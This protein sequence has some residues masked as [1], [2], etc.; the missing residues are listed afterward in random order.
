[1]KVRA[2]LNPRAGVA[3]SRAREAVESGRSSWRDYAVYLTRGAGHATE[4]AREA[5]TAG[6]DLVL[7]VGGD[8]TANEVAQGLLGSPAALGIVPVGSGNGLARALRIPLPPREALAALESGARRR[9]DVGFLNGRPFL[10]VAGVGFDAAVG[11]A[12]HEH[13]RRGG[14]RGLLGYVWL[15]LLALRSYHPPRLTIDVAPERL[16]L[17]AFVATFANGPQYGSGA[18][19]NPGGKLDDGRIE[20]VVFEDGPLWR[21]VAAGSRMFLGGLERARGYRRLAG[22]A[23]TVTAGS[24]APVHCD[25]DP[26][27]AADRIDVELRPRA[28]EIVVPAA[29]ADDH[30]GPFA[31]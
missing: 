19:I 1:M 15:S 6:A 2:I 25:G 30:D 28:L 20:V 13:G 8:G 22:P 14:R 31:G 23:A 27:G 3:G 17:T 12:F 4:L 18:V 7:A 9:M 24:P 26:A 5:V 21:T 11:H 29:T 10:N 16:D